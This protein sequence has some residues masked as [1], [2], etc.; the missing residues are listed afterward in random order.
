MTAYRPEECIVFQSHT[1]VAWEFVTYFNVPT[2][3]TWVRD[4]GGGGYSDV[5]RWHRA[6]LSTWAPPRCRRPPRCRGC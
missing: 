6:V 3:A 5:F 4:R 2:Y 1:F